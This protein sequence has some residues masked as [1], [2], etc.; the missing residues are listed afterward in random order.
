MKK[1]KYNFL[2]II[3]TINFEDVKGEFHNGKRDF[4]RGK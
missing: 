1:G 3:K 4:K 2:E